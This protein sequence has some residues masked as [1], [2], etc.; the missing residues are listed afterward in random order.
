MLQFIVDINRDV[1]KTTVLR[2]IGGGCDEAALN[3]IKKVQFEAGTQRGK[4][5]NVLM[6]VPLVCKLQ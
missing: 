2:G 3:A 6:S 4:P 5:V 1:K